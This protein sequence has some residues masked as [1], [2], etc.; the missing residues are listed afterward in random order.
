MPSDGREEPIFSGTGQPDLRRGLS[1]IPR[2]ASRVPLV[3]FSNNPQ[4]ARDLS[5]FLAESVARDSAYGSCIV[6]FLNGALPA[7]VASGGVRGPLR[8]IPAVLRQRSRLGQYTPWV[9]EARRRRKISRCGQAT[10]GEMIPS[11]AQATRLLGAS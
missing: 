1:A 7:A 10:V 11:G 3:D 6:H 9:A 4:P 8:P 5:Q 2:H